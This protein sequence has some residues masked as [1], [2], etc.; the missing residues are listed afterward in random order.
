M[1]SGINE[2]KSPQLSR[3]QELS[4]HQQRGHLEK[5]RNTNIALRNP[6]IQIGALATTTTTK[7]ICFFF[8]LC[9][10]WDTIAWLVACER[11][12]SSFRLEDEV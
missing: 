7:I 2:V 1:S 11:C 12:V 5:S 10:I 8:F 9:K 4:S 3:R 6:E